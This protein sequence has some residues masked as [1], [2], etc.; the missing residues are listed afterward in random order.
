MFNITQRLFGVVQTNQGQQAGSIVRYF[1]NQKNRDSTQLCRIKEK[2]LAWC[3]SLMENMMHFGWSFIQSSDDDSASQALK[4]ASQ[5]VQSGMQL[6]QNT[7]E[8]V[9]DHFQLDAE[10]MWSEARKNGTD[11]LRLEITYSVGLCGDIGKF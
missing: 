8:S 3:L 11:G 4:G 5:L 2:V 10:D 9:F 6:T 1:T 7:I